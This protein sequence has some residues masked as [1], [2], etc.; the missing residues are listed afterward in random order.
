MTA[1]CVNTA[2]RSFSRYDIGPI[3]HNSFFREPDFL[4][5]KSVEYQIVLTEFQEF[6]IITFMLLSTELYVKIY[7]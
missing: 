4:E 1:E 7:Q 5:A 2:L 3:D 6:L